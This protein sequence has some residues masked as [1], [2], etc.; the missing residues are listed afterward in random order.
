M[1]KYI[2][3]IMNKGLGP[4]GRIVSEAGFKPLT[5]PVIKTGRSE[6][7]AWYAYGLNVETSDGH[8]ILSHTGGMVGYISAMSMDMDV[9]VGAA[10]LSN[11]ATS[12]D[13][14]ARY[15][16]K[17]F[18]SSWTR[19]S[20]LPKD[21]PYAT[22][23]EKPE[24]Y[25]GQYLMGARSILVKRAGNQLLAMHEGVVATLE[26][27]D[28]DSFF[29]E[30]PGF[31]LH[32]MRFR[33]E[34]DEVV[35][36]THGPSVYTREGRSIA[37]EVPFNPVWASY[38]GHYRTHNPWLTNFRVFARKGSLWLTYPSDEEH[39]LFERREGVF[40]VGDPKE[41]PEWIRFYATVGGK[42]QRATL[43]G[44]EYARAFTP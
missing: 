38:S 32:L 25:E 39:E 19:T 26:P 24:E 3:L 6:N 8:S 18:R 30:L 31:E 43:S 1:T 37:A 4:S 40:F 29:L 15:A 42:T 7:D 41:S 28:K 13:D 2:R 17:L 12:V 34:G 20:E 44:E 11:G 14:I 22:T 9:G 5:A 35:E 23:V 21:I 16:V 10:V 36:L 27:R 33:R